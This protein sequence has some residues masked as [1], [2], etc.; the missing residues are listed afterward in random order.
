M[1]I[2]AECLN[3]DFITQFCWLAFALEID[4]LSLSLFLRPPFLPSSLRLLEEVEQAMG[5]FR[6]QRCSKCRVSQTETCGTVQLWTHLQEATGMKLLHSPTQHCLSV[7][8]S[9]KLFV[10]LFLLPVCGKASCPI[11][12]I[13][14]LTLP[15]SPLSVSHCLS[16][17]YSLIVS[18]YLALLQPL[19]LWMRLSWLLWSFVVMTKRVKAIGWR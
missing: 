19:R 15:A 14:F 7:C 16:L 3:S 11:F 8:K 12:T 13:Y 10:R 2:P 4:F 17:P 9:V 6:L 5:G 18:L 1:E